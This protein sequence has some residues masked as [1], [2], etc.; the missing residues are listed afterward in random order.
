VGSGRSIEEFNIT[1]A[2]QEASEHLDRFG[3]HPQACGFSV[4]GEDKMNKAIEIMTEYA[5]KEL[6]GVE[7]V[8][9]LKIDAELTMDHLDW[10][11]VEE[12]DKFRP[13]G[14]HNE[15]PVFVTKKLQIVGT[16]KVGKDGQHLRLT[17]N[18]EKGGKMV[19]LIGFRFGDWA[20]KLALGD[21]V[22]V[23][24]EIG[25]NEWNGNRD[26]QLRIVDII[27]A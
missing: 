16:E 3:G 23:V 21:L 24:Y 20:E 26:I 27:K 6:E 8:P 19:K 18:P 25:V 15:K 12:L 2:M 9:A 11:L 14:T 4:E 22:D 5:K 1:K 13:Y 7:L 10:D 17:A